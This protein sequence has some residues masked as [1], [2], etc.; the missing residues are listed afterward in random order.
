MLGAESCGRRK[1]IDDGD[2]LEK[3]GLK[4]HIRCEIDCYALYAK[5]RGPSGAPSHDW[6]IHPGF[7]EYDDTTKIAPLF[8]EIIQAGAG[9]VK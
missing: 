4:S 9:E 1:V 5:E 8:G 7:A 6:E 3:A 2:E